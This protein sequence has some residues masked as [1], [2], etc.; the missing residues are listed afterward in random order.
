MKL[1]ELLD[2]AAIHYVEAVVDNDEV[3]FYTIDDQGERVKQRS[4]HPIDLLYDLLDYHS[5][6]VES[7]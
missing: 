5:F 3:V 7:A 1:D 6:N 2:F 4:F